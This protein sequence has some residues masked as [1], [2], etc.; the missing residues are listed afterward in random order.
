MINL[1]AGPLGSGKGMLFMSQ[2]LDVLVHTDD[3]IVTNFAIQFQP[4]EAKQLR[5]M[6]DVLGKRYGDVFECEERIRIL[7][8][9][10]CRQFWL[11]PAPGLDMRKCPTVAVVGD[12]QTDHE[13]FPDYSILQRLPRKRIHFFIDEAPDYWDNL[14]FAKVSKGCKHALRHSRKFGWEIWF[15]CQEISQL[16][17]P[18]RV[19]VQNTYMLRNFKHE[20]I[21]KFKH[22]RVIK[23]ER[24]WKVPMGVSP[25][26]MATG[27]M[28]V[29]VSYL[30]Q[31]YDTTAGVGVSGGFVADKQRVERGIP[32][33]MLPA[34]VFTLCMSIWL[35]IWF[36]GKSVGNH[37]MHLVPPQASIS[38][39]VASNHVVTV[40]RMPEPALKTNSV[41]LPSAASDA[42]NTV[43]MTG[44]VRFGSNLKVFLS[45]GRSFDSFDDELQVVTATGCRISG[46]WYDMDRLASV[47][48]FQVSLVSSSTNR[49]SPMQSETATQPMVEQ[50]RLEYRQVKIKYN[51]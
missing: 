18:L 48:A 11:F 39:S 33:W 40:E 35:F 17:K 51:N 7:S 12:G 41:V 42:R 19:F 10:E 2:I 25:I 5:G 23:W 22:R 4:N 3:Y 34:G 13:S 32:F 6:L 45:D 44:S 14:D 26:P 37:F 38:S 24:Y 16:A 36:G 49:V 29:D 31:M 28:P 30:G 43:Y 21:G 15:S 27:T 9:D 50:P 1:V 46:K 8:D 47:R 20:K